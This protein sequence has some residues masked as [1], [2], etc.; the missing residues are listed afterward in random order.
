[1]A[2]EGTAPPGNPRGV[3][4][5]GPVC[6]VGR[7]LPPLGRRGLSTGHPHVSQS[8][9]GCL[10]VP[11]PHLHRTSRGAFP[12][13]VSIAQDREGIVERQTAVPPRGLQTSSSVRGSGKGPAPRGGAPG[14]R[15][16]GGGQA[17]VT[18]VPERS[19][20]ARNWLLGT[21]FQPRFAGPQDHRPAWCASSKQ[22]RRAPFRG[23]C[24]GHHSF[25]A[26]LR[27]GQRTPR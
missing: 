13:P 7:A 16:L 14:L 10:L 22:A 8:S 24:R 26:H 9:G 1:M 5:G 27:R 3:G 11:R 23:R 4:H 2:E 17:A 20:Q 19:A 25:G 21:K 18:E 12:S 15:G 6:G